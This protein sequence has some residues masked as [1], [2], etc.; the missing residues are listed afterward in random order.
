MAELKCI[1]T[2]ACSMNKE[3]ELQ[4]TV[5]QQNCDVVTIMETWWG[6]SH[7]WRAALAREETF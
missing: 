6:D 4:A 5:Q 7:S 3:E 1:Y 2:N